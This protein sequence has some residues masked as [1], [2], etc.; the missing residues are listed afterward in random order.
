MINF[1]E[2]VG[3]TVVVHGMDGQ[4]YVGSLREY[5]DETDW[6]LLEQAWQIRLIPS[7]Q[8]VGVMPTPI[9]ISG[10]LLNTF[11]VKIATLYGAKDMA[12][13][14]RK[15]LDELESEMR[16]RLSGIQLSKPGG[17]HIR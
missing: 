3:E 7:Q 8:G 5:D 12:V 9:G 4:M 1:A 11:P 10:A 13:E 16:A 2:Y 14:G 17:G 15:T 6:V